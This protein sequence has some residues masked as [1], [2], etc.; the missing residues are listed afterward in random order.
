[1]ISG[2]SSALTN[3]IDPQPLVQSRP[4]ERGERWERHYRP[5][6]PC[7]PWLICVS[8]LLFKFSFSSAIKHK[9]YAGGFR[10]SIGKVASIS[11]HDRQSGSPQ[12][13]HNREDM[14][15]VMCQSILFKLPFYGQIRPLN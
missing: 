13:F 5:A 9:P 2:L 1:V 15:W 3:Q 8:Q 11:F 10:S 6:A 4:R 12:L 14:S 7:Y